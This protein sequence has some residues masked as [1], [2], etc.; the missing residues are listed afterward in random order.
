VKKREKNKEI[1]SGENEEVFKNFQ[2]IK[3]MKWNKKGYS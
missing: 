3:V 2:K 1:E